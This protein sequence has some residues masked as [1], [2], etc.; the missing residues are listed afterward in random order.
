MLTINKTLS[1][2]L[3]LVISA[4]V[5]S[6]S[7]TTNAV[8]DTDEVLSGGTYGLMTYEIRLDESGEKYASITDC[9]DTIS[10]NV[11][12]P[13]TIEGTPVKEID[14][15]AFNYCE[16]ITSVTF[17]DTLEYIRWGAFYQ[18]Y[19]LGAVHIPASVRSIEPNA[20]YRCY[21]TEFT[22]DYGLESLVG[23]DYNSFTEIDLPS[24]VSYVKDAFYKCGYLKKLVVRNPKCELIMSDWS[25]SDSVVIYGYE[26]STAQV[27]ANELG[28]EFVSLGKVLRGDVN[29]D[30]A[31]DPTD[32]TLV[33]SQYTVGS[34]NGSTLLD[35]YQETAADV[36]NDGVI[37]PV[38]ATWIL[39]YYAYSS[40]NGVGS[41]EDF[42]TNN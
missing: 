22:I 25:L 23:L 35:G 42:I 9:D 6:F 8:S 24:S 37:D 4:S 2:A 5:F 27:L 30:K 13:S 12:I 14:N 38:D 15:G 16:G 20:F 17:P 1:L 29:I 11:M 19:S 39:R 40:M 31:I 28:N 7:G 36:N 32:A 26:G 3:S 21:I 10:G 18:A 41:I 33:L 34:M